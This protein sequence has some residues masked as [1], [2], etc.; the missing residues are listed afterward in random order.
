MIAE[1][2]VG[3]A[4]KARVL[5]V[6]DDDGTRE[7]YQ[8]VLRLAGYDVVT[9]S[10]GRDAIAALH[11]YHIDL[12]LTDVH[13]PDVSGLEVL[14]EAKER[15]P[16]LPV[17]VY[18]AAGSTALDRAAHHLGAIHFS[19]S[20]WDCESVVRIAEQF[21]RPADAATQATGGVGPATVRWV[22]I[23]VPVVDS[24][25]DVPTLVQWSDLIAHSVTTIKRY[26][27]ACGVRAADSLNF[28][29]ALRVV[30]AGHRA[31][32]EWYNA[33]NILD[34]ATMKSFR[35]RAGVERHSGHFSVLTFLVDQTFVQNETLLNAI[36]AALDLI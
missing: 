6:D 21:R 29:R 13:M 12:L 27:R 23:V 17:V 35:T 33:L 26:C 24:G 32:A 20:L 28:A 25:D 36:R 2:A 5:L 8:R 22:G 4:M 3:P 14:A 34:P 18:S 9:A 10:A 19:W 11:T 15:D 16:A 30:R 7:T 1:G 31:P